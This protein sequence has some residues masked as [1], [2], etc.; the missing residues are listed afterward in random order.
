M[1]GIFSAL[2]NAGTRVSIKS[3]CGV[4]KN[5]VEWIRKTNYRKGITFSPSSS[6]GTFVQLADMELFSIGER[7]LLA[8]CH[9][10]TESGGAANGW[11]AFYMDGS[12]VH[13]PNITAIGQYIP[14]GNYYPKALNGIA[15]GLFG[16]HK[17]ETRWYVSSGTYVSYG[18]TRIMTVQEVE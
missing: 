17:I 18:K 9:T 16:L 13:I 11:E 3:Y 15:E 10:T 5:Y 12:Q 6:S 1:S 2:Y 4:K 14:D 7:Y 8:G